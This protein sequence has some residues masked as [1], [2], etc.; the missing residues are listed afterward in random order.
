MRFTTTTLTTTTDQVVEPRG[1]PAE[2]PAPPAETPR[3]PRAFRTGRNR[4]NA[5]PRGWRAIDV[6]SRVAEV[7][8]R[9][10]Y[11]AEQGVVVRRAGSR[12]V[13]TKKDEVL[14]EVPAVRL[15]GVAVYGNVQVT[16][17][18][19]R[20]LVQEDVW[21]SFFTRGGQYRARVQPAAERGG[22]L[23]RRQWTR[24]NDGPF[25]LAFA[26]ALVR[27]KIL[28]QRR[29]TEAYAKNRAA[30]SLCTGHRQL[31]ECLGRVDEAQDLAALRGV[32]GTATRAYFG[33]FARWNRSELPFEG[34]EKRGTADPINA[35][36]NFGYSLLTRE[37]EGL[38]EAAGLD[39]T[40]GFYHCLDDDR[41]SLACDLVEELRH[42]V[43]DRLVLTLVNKRMVQRDDFEEGDDRRPLQLSRDGLRK[44]LVAYERAMNRGVDEHPSSV[45]AGV[46]SVLL[47]Q[48]GRLLDAMAGRAE[49]RTF[50]EA[51]PA[52]D[53]AAGAARPSRAAAARPDMAD[54]HAAN[55]DDRG[56]SVEE[57]P[58]V[59]DAP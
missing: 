52:P 55:A 17:Q 21:V 43:I 40:I 5:K 10:L 23:R 37:I 41:P 18:C 39:P 57:S 36:L 54:G 24:A 50:C 34:R 44:V 6:S 46:R 26:K 58:P 31:R 53:G 1:R 49:Y 16:T 27:G 51:P 28:S 14:L 3:V 4:E 29:L 45:A 33:L 59:K 20:T 42:L 12:V 38:T 32:E 35:L 11:V 2:P 56:G 8:S 15:Q 19:L 9:F 48:I 13:V 22:R 47:V 30:E 7:G 25:C